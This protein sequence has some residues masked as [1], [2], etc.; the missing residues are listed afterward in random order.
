MHVFFKLMKCRK[1]NIL[2]V[3]VYAI[4]PEY[5]HN[6]TQLLQLPSLSNDEY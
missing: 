1:I 6:I 3:Y 4:N 5:T 2:N